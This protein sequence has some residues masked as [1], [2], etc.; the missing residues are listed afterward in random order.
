MKTRTMVVGMTFL[1]TAFVALYLITRPIPFSVGVQ[2]GSVNYPM[3]YAINN[4]FFE[5]EKLK[6]EVKIFKSAND[7]LEALLG[8]S[9]FIDAVIPIQNIAE[10]QNKQPGII[11]I[12]A[13]LLSDQEH[14]LDYLVVLKTSG[15]KS[16]R[17]LS[18]KTIVVF[19]GSYSETVTRLALKKIGIDNVKYIKRSPDD[20]VQAL[21]TG[22]ADA[23]VFYD[24]IATQSEINGWGIIIERG[25][26]EHYLK[27]VI[28]VGAYAFNSKE[29][30]K[31]P[32]IARQVYKAISAAVISGRKEPLKAKM[33]IKSY[34]HTEDNIISK[35]PESK[36][37][38]AEEIDPKIIEETLKIY[39]DNGIISKAPDLKNIL[40]N[41]GK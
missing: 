17:D 23:G 29:V 13:L 40:Y 7:A 21:R 15:I 10:I 30:E 35:L 38:L 2:P 37:V 5:K 9:I 26:W 14:P 12:A 28:V 16:V 36:V 6:P 24:P 33:A 34:L 39:E 4:G 18:G 1:L 41:V 27:P 3:M 19:P 31:K 8:G 20:M 22:E 25:F 32:D 11:S